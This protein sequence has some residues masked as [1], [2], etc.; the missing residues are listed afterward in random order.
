MENRG[1]L[2]ILEVELSIIEKKV[3]ELITFSLKTIKSDP[4]LEK[5]ILKM[6]MGASTRVTNHFMI[7]T[8]N[9]DTQYVGKN[10]MK[11]AMFKKL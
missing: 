9:T 11:Y 8:E 7:E 1:T 5:E 4:S 2:E 6:F 3:N 10:V